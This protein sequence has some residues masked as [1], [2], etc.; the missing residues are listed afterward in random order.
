MTKPDARSLSQESQ[1]DLRIR[2][3]HA[4]VDGM[5]QTEAVR[6]FQV[7]RAAF[8]KWMKQ[9][10]AGGWKALRS[11]PKGRPRSPSRLKGW[12][13]AQVVR[14]ITDRSRSVET[15]VCAVDTGGGSGFAGATVWGAGF[16]VYP[17]LHGLI[18]SRNHSP[19]LFSRYATGLTPLLTGL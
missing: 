18:S 5:K 11:R 2:V 4:V 1:E 17:D 13:A 9:Y 12:Q 8:C 3:V 16:S 7:S 6:V 14:T 19:R 10:R 15:S